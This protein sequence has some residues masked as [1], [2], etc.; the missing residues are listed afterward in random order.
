M[1]KPLI[2]LLLVLLSV[3][4]CSC[5]KESDDKPSQEK[6]ESL[7]TCQPTIYAPI[8]DSVAQPE[9]KTVAPVPESNSS[10]AE[11]KSVVDLTV[12]SNTMVYAEVYNML[13]APEDYIGR[14]VKM[15]GQ[16]SIYQDSSTGVSYYACVI[17]DATACCSQGIEFVLAGEHSYPEDYPALGT[18]IIVLGEFQTYSEDGM[19]YPHLVN[20][21]LL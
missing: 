3:L 15:A 6:N 9:A 18:E 21:Q 10:D 8:I 19:L 12:L 16:F 13:V 20:A 11:Y 2:I 14:T 7:K 5:G 1:N 17:A 4:L